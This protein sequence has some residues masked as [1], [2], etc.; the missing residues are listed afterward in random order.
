M[1]RNVNKFIK[2]KIIYFV[3]QQVEHR[4]GSLALDHWIPLHLL[5]DAV[6]IRGAATKK[7]NLTF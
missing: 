4:I 5:C 1:K 3:E 6:I 7:Q 2:D